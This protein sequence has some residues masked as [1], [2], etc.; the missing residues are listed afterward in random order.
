MATIEA[1]RAQGPVT[2]RPKARKRRHWLNADRRQRI[3]VCSMAIVTGSAT[4]AFLG[5]YLP[6]FR[7]PG[8]WCLG[9]ALAGYTIAG[10]LLVYLWKVCGE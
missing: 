7:L 3:A 5:P 6:T 9:L 1:P 2:A 8:P 4:T 10:A